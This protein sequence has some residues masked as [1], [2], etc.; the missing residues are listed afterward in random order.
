MQQKITCMQNQQQQKDV[1]LTR[2]NLCPYIA[3]LSH[4][5]IGGVIF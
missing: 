2:Q 3:P 4:F 5:H 1:G